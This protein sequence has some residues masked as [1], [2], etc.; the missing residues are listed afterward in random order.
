MILS[1]S[2]T[3]FVVGLNSA[4]RIPVVKVVTRNFFKRTL[5]YEKT[6]QVANPAKLGDGWLWL[7]EW[8]QKMVASKESAKKISRKCRYSSL[9]EKASDI[10]AKKK[11]YYESS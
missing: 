8:D 7:S 4:S 5:D 6:G 3:P 11:A 1:S 10:R 9:S 2:V